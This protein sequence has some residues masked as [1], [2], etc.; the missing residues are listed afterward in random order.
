MQFFIDT[1]D[2]AEIKKYWDM[3]LIDGVTTN[4]SL[5][6]QVGRPFKE[7]VK[8]IFGIVNGPISLEVL[9]TD[10]EGIMREAK[11]LSLLNANVVVKVP[12][13]P[14][15]LKAVKALSSEGIKTNVTLVF[16]TS[17]AL[18]AAKA[19]ATYVSPFLGR[20]DD[21]GQDSSLLLEEIVTVMANYDFP[22]KVLA[23]S[24]RS[25]RQVAL[26]ALL[27]ADVATIPPAILEKLAQHPLTDKGLEKFL[28][29]YK[30]AGL[31]PLV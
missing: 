2:P 21:I 12:L 28:K 13:I 4:P 25:S 7:L 8:E 17:Q 31:E 23:A 3:G 10:F 1:A 27:G 20:L 29:D 26:A 11:S 6:S 18:L 24:I 15:G 5:A 9:S 22:T 19:G 16:S 30:E 14:E